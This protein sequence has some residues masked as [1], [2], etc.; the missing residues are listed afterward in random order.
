MKLMTSFTHL[1]IAKCYHT[2]AMFLWRSSAHR[3]IYNCI[4]TIISSSSSNIITIIIII[5]I[6]QFVPGIWTGPVWQHFLVY[7]TKLSSRMSGSQLDPVL[8]SPC[9]SLL[10]RFTQGGH[11][12]ELLWDWVSGIYS[13]IHRPI[14]HCRAIWVDGCRVPL[15]IIKLHPLQEILRANLVLGGDAAHPVNHSTVVTL[16]VLQVG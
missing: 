15:Q 12:H 5:T 10:S 2:T 11:G 9:R 3:F 1:L 16:Q 14:L 6:M 8:G 13:T 7:H 4:T